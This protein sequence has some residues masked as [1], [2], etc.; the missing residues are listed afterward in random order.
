MTRADSASEGYGSALAKL[1]RDK[2]AEFAD[3][4]NDFSPEDLGEAEATVFAEFDVSTTRAIAQFRPP[5]FALLDTTSL[6]FQHLYTGIGNADEANRANLLAALLAANVEARGPLRLSR[7]QTE[8]LAETLTGLGTALDKQKL[9]RFAESAFARAAHLYLETENHSA[10]D[11]CLYRRAAARHAYRPHDWR[12]RMETVSNLLVGYGGHRPFR[13]LG[14]LAVQLA[15]VCAV[16]ISV[17]GARQPW[18]DTL[19]TTVQNF[20]NPMG[21]R[22]T[23]LM[24]HGVRAA[25][26]FESYLGAVALSVFFALLT[27]KWFRI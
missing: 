1:I 2:A 27:R 16:V 26:A 20:I 10:R 5:S 25:L 23:D 7:A 14:W 15:V 11:D 4:L 6:L 22:N 18:T 19:Y 8:N 24:P 3:E 21:I 9:H 12:R 17:P 13:L